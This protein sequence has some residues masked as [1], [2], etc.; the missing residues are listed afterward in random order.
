MAEGEVFEPAEVL[1]TDAREPPRLEQFD[2][3]AVVPRGENLV[4]KYDVEL[5]S[6]PAANFRHAGELKA[7]ILV[8]EVALVALQF[9]D[10][11]RPVMKAHLDV[12]GIALKATTERKLETASFGLCP[13]NCRIYLAPLDE[14]PLALLRR[15][16]PFTAL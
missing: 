11:S 16:Q 1:R 13:F 3:V 9:D 12:T 14:V 6:D 5:P 10:L 15:L 7:V 8:V 4:G 2:I